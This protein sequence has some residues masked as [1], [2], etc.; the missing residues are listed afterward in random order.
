[1]T[2]VVPAL[3]GALIVAGLIGGYLSVHDHG[4]VH[5]GCQGKGRENGHTDQNLFH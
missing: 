5:S 3:G 1:M 4:V 2:P